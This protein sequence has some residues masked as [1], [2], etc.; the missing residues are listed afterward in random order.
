[1]IEDKTTGFTK[2]A[3]YQV[4]VRK[5]IQGSHLDVWNFL[6][7]DKGLSIWLGDADPE[8]LI[9]RE[10]ITLSDGTI[11][12]ITRF[13]LQSHLRMRWRK[14]SWDSSSRLQLRVIASGYHRTT[15]A[16]HQEMLDSSAQREDMKRH[17]KQVL[18][19]LEAGLKNRS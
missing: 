15:L 12:K 11:V 5:T 8:K 14:K 18:A 6:L 2:D 19:N 4:G 3:G 7:S 16:F 9:L 10:E 1:M 17:W 13:K